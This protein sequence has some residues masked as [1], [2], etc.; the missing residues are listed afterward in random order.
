MHCIALPLVVNLSSPCNAALSSILIA[1]TTAIVD[2]DGL[3]EV[4]I[5][6]LALLS[7]SCD[8]PVALRLSELI[9]V[10]EECRKGCI[11]L[12]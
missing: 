9:D 8:D 3:V 12:L 4:V 1:D 5:G 11:L 6:R 10:F 7:P 2:E